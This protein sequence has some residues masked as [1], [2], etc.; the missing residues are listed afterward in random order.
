MKSI[1]MKKELSAQSPTNEFKLI[2]SLIITP[3]PLYQQFWV[4]MRMKFRENVSLWIYI[5]LFEK[6][7]RMCP[8]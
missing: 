3:I 8:K 4:K 2:K 6:T 5:T 1:N 7:Y